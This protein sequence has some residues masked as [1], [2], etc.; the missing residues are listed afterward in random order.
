MSEEPSDRYEISDA[1]DAA[2]EA[3]SGS[4]LAGIVVALIFVPIAAFLRCLGFPRKDDQDKV[5]CTGGTPAR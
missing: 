4:P 5:K 3:T 1:L 2:G